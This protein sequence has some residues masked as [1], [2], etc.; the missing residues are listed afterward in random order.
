[1]GDLVGLLR[2]GNPRQQHLSG[3]NP[4]FVAVNMDGS[5]MR[6]NNQCF[7]PVIEAADDNVPGDGMI[8]PLQ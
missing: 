1:M 3:L 2:T 8:Q 4:H 7:G 6:L 5:Q